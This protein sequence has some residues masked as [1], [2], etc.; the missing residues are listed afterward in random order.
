MRIEP[1]VVERKN[2][3]IFE[4]KIIFDLSPLNTAKLY[5]FDKKKCKTNNFFLYE[6]KWTFIYLDFINLLPCHL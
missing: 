4:N 6:V 1:Y 2:R 5:R 3:F